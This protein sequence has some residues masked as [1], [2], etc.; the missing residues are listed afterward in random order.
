MGPYSILRIFFIL[1]GSTYVK[2]VSNMPYIKAIWHFCQVGKNEKGAFQNLLY[3]K[4]IWHLYF[5]SNFP[6]RKKEAFQRPKI[7]NRSTKRNFQVLHFC[8]SA[9]QS[10]WI[11]TRFP[12]SS[13]TDTTQYLFLSFPFSS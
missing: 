8:I 3:I 1:R 6:G 4:G 5:L 12:F 13:N 7:E 2:K 11:R 9:R 10:L